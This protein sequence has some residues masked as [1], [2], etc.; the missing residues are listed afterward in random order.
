MITLVD[1]PDMDESLYPSDNMSTYLAGP[2]NL[3][4]PGRPDTILAVDLMQSGVNITVWDGGSGLEFSSEEFDGTVSG[5]GKKITFTG[6]EKGI[7]NFT[8]TPA[9]Y[10][11]LQEGYSYLTFSGEDEAV[12]IIRGLIRRVAG[13]AFGT[14]T[15]GKLTD[16]GLVLEDGEDNVLGLY[17]I[18]KDG[19]FK[20]ENGAWVA[21]DPDDEEANEEIEGGIWVEALD[22]IKQAYDEKENNDSLVLS[23]FQGLTI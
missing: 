5:D 3:Q 6:K 7:G 17:V 23:D 19:T 2:F 16:L 14:Y 22:G 11:D 20:R 12:R 13:S 8:I 10:E 1:E 9:S 21:I 15:G 4:A 18:N